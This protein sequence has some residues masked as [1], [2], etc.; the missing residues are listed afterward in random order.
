MSN[1]SDITSRGFRHHRL[2][3][4]HCATLFYI[5]YCKSG[6]GRAFYVHSINLSRRMKVSTRAR[7]STVL[8]FLIGLSVVAAEAQ[9]GLLFTVANTPMVSNPAFSG[10][11]LQLFPQA[12]L[13]YLQMGSAFHTPYAEFR[14]DIYSGRMGVH[15]PRYFRPIHHPCWNYSWD[16]FLGLFN[17][18]IWGCDLLPGQAY[19]S[20]YRPWNRIFVWT[21]FHSRTPPH[22]FTYWRDPF[23]PPWGPR[24]TQDPWAPFWDG[25]W[26]EPGFGG[27]YP[28]PYP[29][30][31]AIAEAE[32]PTR[33]AT[34]RPSSRIASPR[35]YGEGSARV[36]G[37]SAVP[38]ASNPPGRWQGIPVLDSRDPKEPTARP[39][40]KGAEPPPSDFIYPPSAHPS[41]DPRRGSRAGSGKTAKAPRPSDRIGLGTI[42]GTKAGPRS[43]PKSRDRSPYPSFD[44]SPA[45]GNGAS[46][47]PSIGR[48]P[49]PRTQGQ[50][51]AYPQSSGPKAEPNPAPRAKVAPPPSRAPKVRATPRTSPKMSPRPSRQTSRSPSTARR[52][53]RPGN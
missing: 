10:F 25:Y 44:R 8:V 43:K 15:Q 47:H 52:A 16:P 27:H 17:D 34:R 5:D 41:A 13:G 11:S 20:T 48:R 18:W 29:A 21:S 46:N 12:P 2:S 35:G 33:T 51:K 45:P 50:P 49:S 39:T 26:D 31:P 6:I 4:N 40:A 19:G 1:I 24:W 3:I 22:A 23:V 7:T 32:A 30:M 28:A 9:R 36:P 37:R 53:Q 42:S 14:Y 38:R